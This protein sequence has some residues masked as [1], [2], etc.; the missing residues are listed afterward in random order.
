MLWVLRCGRQTLKGTAAHCSLQDVGVAA[1]AARATQPARQLQ[2]A[3]AT[4]WE[5]LGVEMALA[6]DQQAADMASDSHTRQLYA[7]RCTVA[8][9]VAAYS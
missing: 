7:I 4:A 1:A 5:Y 2:C 8:R 9:C 6:R 3:A